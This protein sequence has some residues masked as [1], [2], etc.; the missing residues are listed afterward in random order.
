MTLRPGVHQPRGGPGDGLD[1]AAQRGHGRAVQ[2]DPVKPTLKAPGTNL[3]TL[4]CDEPLSSFAFK[5]NL[6]RYTMA[7]HV[8][9]P[10]RYLLGWMARQ[11]GAYTRPLFGST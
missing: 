10:S 8:I 2:V 1:G 11:A 4:K 9:S 3:L 7:D 6:R 5:F